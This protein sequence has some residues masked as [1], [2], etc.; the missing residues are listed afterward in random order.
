LISGAFDV[1][2]AVERTSFGDIPIVGFAT[3]PPRLGVA[4]VEISEEFRRERNVVVGTHVNRGLEESPVHKGQHDVK[5]GHAGTDLGPVPRADAEAPF[6]VLKLSDD[7]GLLLLGRSHLQQREPK[8]EMVVVVPLVS[9]YSR[10]AKRPSP[11][12]M[13]RDPDHTGRFDDSV[14][15]SNTLG[16]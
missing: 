9:L 14:Y 15:H 3:S 12:V 11:R 5:D 10:P 4:L 1:V 16:E 6:G 2:V 13:D 8:W 7:G